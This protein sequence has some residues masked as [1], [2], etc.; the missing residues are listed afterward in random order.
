[1]E[2]AEKI[3]LIAYRLWLVR[4]DRHLSGDANCDYYQAE[5]IF[6]S[7]KNL[8]LLSLGSFGYSTALFVLGH[9]TEEQYAAAMN[10]VTDLPELP[11]Q[12]DLSLELSEE[13]LSLSSRLRFL[14]SRHI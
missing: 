10:V 14:K 13:L 9:S 3:K 2:K 8:Q 4:R 7:Y 12:Y 1:M 6:E 11:E 5:R